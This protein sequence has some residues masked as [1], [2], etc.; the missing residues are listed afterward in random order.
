MGSP[1][2]LES[3]MDAREP[4]PGFSRFERYVAVLLGV[5][6][7]AGLWQGY[8]SWLLEVVRAG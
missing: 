8:G 2:V 7:A 1:E 5:V 4:K 6:I 3:G